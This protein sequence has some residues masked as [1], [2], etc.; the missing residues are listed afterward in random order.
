[1]DIISEFGS[2]VD[3]A[4]GPDAFFGEISLTNNVPRTASVKATSPCV[5]FTLEKTEF[6]KLAAKYPNISKSISD[7][8]NNRMQ[9]YLERNVLA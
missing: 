5:T 3:S 4:A 1:V 6:E 9:A 7:A 8:S 2:K